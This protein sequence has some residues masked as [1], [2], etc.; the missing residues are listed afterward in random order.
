MN[1]DTMFKIQD[2]DEIFEY[3][4]NKRKGYGEKIDKF[5]YGK[6]TKCLKKEKSLY[7][8]FKSYNNSHLYYDKLIIWEIKY[9]RFYKKNVSSAV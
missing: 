8:I 7:E 6:V 9:G 3:K 1:F 5:E 2:V 4:N